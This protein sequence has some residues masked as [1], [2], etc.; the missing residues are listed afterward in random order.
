MSLKARIEAAF[1]KYNKMLFDGS[2]KDI[3]I[4]TDKSKYPGTCSAKVVRLRGDKELK[5]VSS[6]TIRLSEMYDWSD[7]VK[8]NGTVI[9]EM[10]HAYFFTKL[11]DE[12]HGPAFIAMCVKLS[13]KVGFEIPK[14]EDHIGILK[15]ETKRSVGY[16]VLYN[17]HTKEFTVMFV[18]A[19]AFT[20]GNVYNDI[21]RRLKSNY[22]VV[23]SGLTNSN[24]YLPYVVKR[25]MKKLAFYKISE[26]DLYDLVTQRELEDFYD[27][28]EYN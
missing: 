7:E 21:E 19:N 10:I 5:S 4:S 23:K 1:V 2:L 9:H 14:T 17:E 24:V 6:I 16:I 12:R 27:F 26:K 18:T 8:F 11:L 22:K 28:Y 25:S 3:K 15:Q 13:K 20:A